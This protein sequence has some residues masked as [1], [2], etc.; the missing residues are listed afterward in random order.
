MYA[1]HTY[2][3]DGK[4]IKELGIIES[5]KKN[6]IVSFHQNS[7]V[8]TLLLNYSIRSNS[9]IQKVS[10]NLNTK[11]IKNSNVESHNDFAA[12]F[13]EKNRSV[14]IYKTDKKIFFKQFVGIDNVVKNEFLF[15]NDTYETKEFFEDNSI[16]AIKTSEFISN[17]STAKLKAY[18]NKNTVFFTNEN[19][20]KSSTQLLSFSLTENKLEKPNRKTYTVRHEGSSLKRATSF[21]NEDEIYQLVLDKKGGAIVISNIIYGF[22]IKRIDLNSSINSKIKGNK[23]FQGIEKFLKNASKKK[24]NPT[25]T[26]NKTNTNKVRIRVDY[27]DITYSYNYNWWWEHNHMMHMNNFHNQQIRVSIP[28]NFGPSQPSFYDFEN[29]TIAKEKRFFELVIDEKGVI[30]NEELPTTTYKEINKKEYI[31]KLENITNLYMAS[32]CF[33]KNSFRYIGYN[34]NLK[35]FIIQTSTLK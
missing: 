9:F 31:N 21:I 5:K 16:A 20:R 12:S 32:S 10:V 1:V 26:A 14:L 28:R 15:E 27:V 22:K 8:L 18:L 19:E 33:L 13:R 25:I 35:E 29:A 30:Y 24:Y 34:R 6:D 23:E 4:D 2:V 11:E 17:G 3:Y 7:N